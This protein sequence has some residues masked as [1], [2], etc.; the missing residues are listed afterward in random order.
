MQRRFMLF[1][2]LAIAAC[3]AATRP[4]Q[5]A[6]ELS[7]QFFHIEPVVPVMQLLA[8]ALTASPPL[9]KSKCRKND[10]IE[11]NELDAGTKLD[12]RYATSNNFLGTPAGAR[13]PAAAGSGGPRARAKKASQSTYSND[14]I[15]TTATGSRTRPR[16]FVS[17]KLR[18]RD[19]LC[20]NVCRVPGAQPFM[21]SERDH[22]GRTR[23]RPFAQRCRKERCVS[24]TRTFAS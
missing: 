2:P 3:S 13:L 21:E 15:S 16:M 20:I 17:S 23:R 6:P 24:L 5:P 11:L 14:G 4:R 7:P 10:L 9:G 22:V 1:L 12:I 19:D 8:L 18:Q